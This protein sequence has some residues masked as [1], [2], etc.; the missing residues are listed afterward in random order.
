MRRC[1]RDPWIKEELGCQGAPRGTQ[2]EMLQLPRAA[3]DH[4]LPKVLEGSHTST[5][6]GSRLPWSM[7]SG[8]KS[9]HG[10]FCLDT[11]ERSTCLLIQCPCDL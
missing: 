11:Q 1:L 5:G 4:S 2:V 7:T 3:F 8:D 10:T 6:K 9:G